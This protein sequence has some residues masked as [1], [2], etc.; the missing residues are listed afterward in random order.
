MVLA[1]HQSL[2]RRSGA[3]ALWPQSAAPEHRAGSSSQSL[4]QPDIPT[5]WVRLTLR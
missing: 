3:L 1:G 4:K 5:A 2:L